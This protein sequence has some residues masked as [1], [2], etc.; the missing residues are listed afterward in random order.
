MTMYFDNVY[1][2]ATNL[3]SHFYTGYL[4]SFISSLLDNGCCGQH[5][6]FRL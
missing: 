3:N 4:S 6:T 2:T 1:F 5:S